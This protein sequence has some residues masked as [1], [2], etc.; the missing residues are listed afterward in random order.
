MFVD[1]AASRGLVT[2]GA[3]VAGGGR[4]VGVAA[5][6]HEDILTVAYVAYFNEQN[7]SS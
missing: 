5:A 6:R 3:R 2:V 7:N 1:L 4:R